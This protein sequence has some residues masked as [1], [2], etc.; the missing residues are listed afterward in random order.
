MPE[1][2]THERAC[3]L[4]KALADPTRLRMIRLL[5]A[6][7]AEMCVCEFVDCLRQ[8]QYN[9]SRH[10]KALHA[11]GLIAGEKEG[12][13]VYYRLGSAAGDV[14]ARVHRLVAKLDADPTF[15]GDQ[16][17]FEARM[18]MRSNGRCHIGIQTRG[19]ER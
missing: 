13:W 7:E 17:R 19:L 4:F 18:R 5:A 12:R 6:N 2:T 10:L 1:L 15:A 8:R 3:V 11:C 14:A 9:V 16:K